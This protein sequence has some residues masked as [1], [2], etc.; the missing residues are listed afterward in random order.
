MASG[1]KSFVM[2]TDWIHTFDQLSPEEAGRLIT[3]IL[4]YMNNL[5]PD[6]PDRITEIVFASMKSSLDR[7]TY[8][9][10]A[11]HWNWKGGVT[12]KN[13][14]IRNSSS[15]RLWRLRILERDKYTC[16]HCGYNGPT[17]HVHHIKQFA[18]FPDS[19]FNDD[20]G[21]VLCKSCHINIHRRNGKK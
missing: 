7:S 8:N 20:N 15:A 19:R 16:Q 14:S 13:R 21:I 6:K 4:Q 17:L 9:D 2:Y 11:K 10:G 18:T 5:K 3:Y 1:K 12:P